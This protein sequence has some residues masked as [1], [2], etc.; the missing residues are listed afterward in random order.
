MRKK[1]VTARQIKQFYNIKAVY[2]RHFFCLQKPVDSVGKGLYKTT[3]YFG[4]CVSHEQGSDARERTSTSIKYLEKKNIR[5]HQ[6]TKLGFFSKILTETSR[7]T[8]L[9][10]LPLFRAVSRKRLVRDRDQKFFRDQDRDRSRS[11][12]CL[13]DRDWQTSI[14]RTKTG[15]N[16]I[17]I[18]F[19]N[20]LKKYLRLKFAHKLV[21]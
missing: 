18:N 10:R 9:F 13:R 5:L 12:L 16:D 1:P 17:I 4:R 3:F 8:F 7:K 14:P 20:F 21:L 11:R 6:F 19:F 2:C 15:K